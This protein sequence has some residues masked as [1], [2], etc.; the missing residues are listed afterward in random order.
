M[1]GDGDSGHRLAGCHVQCRTGADQSH[2][3]HNDWSTSRRL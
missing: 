2:S 1:L 3:Y